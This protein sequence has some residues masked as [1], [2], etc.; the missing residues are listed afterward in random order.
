MGKKATIKNDPKK[1]AIAFQVTDNTDA[2]IVATFD[3][4]G[5]PLQDPDSNAGMDPDVDPTSIGP[6]IEQIPMEGP[7]RTIAV[8]AV[9]PLSTVATKMVGLRVEGEIEVANLQVP[10]VEGQQGEVGFPYNL[11]VGQIAQANVEVIVYHVQA[12]Q[13]PTTQT[14]AGNQPNKLTP[15]YSPEKKLLLSCVGT[16]TAGVSTNS[17]KLTLDLKSKGTRNFEKGDGIGLV[18]ISRAFLGSAT[19]IVPLSCSISLIFWL[20][21]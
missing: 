15:L 14:F 19:L 17:T 5:F 16:V 10:L 2:N 11:A 3:A 7:Q 8:G 4:M 21:N 9:T 6:T 12:T 18:V 1:L 13:S 20:Q